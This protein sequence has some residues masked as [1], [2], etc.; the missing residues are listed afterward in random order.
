MFALSIFIIER[1]YYN[2]VRFDEQAIK[3]T[4]DQ[5]IEMVGGTYAHMH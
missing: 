4:T 2:E 3:K 1:F 5:F